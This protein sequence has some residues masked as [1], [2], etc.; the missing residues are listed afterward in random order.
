MAHQT[1]ARLL[2]S[3]PPPLQQHP[4]LLVRQLSMAFQTCQTLPP[5]LTHHHLPPTQLPL[6][7]AC[8]MACLHLLLL[9][10]LLL[11]RYRH[12][13]LLLLRLPV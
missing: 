5:V 11:H 9:L 12:L 1:A 7:L 13:L 4:L 8:Q 2:P 3:L 10:L 6:L